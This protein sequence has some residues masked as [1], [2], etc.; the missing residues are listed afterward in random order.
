MILVRVNSFEGGLAV[1]VQRSLLE[2]KWEVIKF[3]LT[4][5][6]GPTYA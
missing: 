4:N 2:W 6:G 3:M 1:T 5:D